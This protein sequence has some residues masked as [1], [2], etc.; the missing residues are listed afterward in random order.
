MRICGDYITGQISAGF[1]GIF[2]KMLDT[3]VNNWP[4]SP[5]PQPAQDQRT[6]GSIQSCSHF[7]QRINCIVSSSIYVLVCGY[8]HPN[9]TPRSQANPGGLIP[10]L[11][12]H[13]LLFIFKKMKHEYVHL[14][15]HVWPMKTWEGKITEWINLKIIKLI[16]TFDWSSH[17]LC[18]KSAIW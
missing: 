9:T 17:S 18:T 6:W 8:E 5:S 4:N 10:I 16:K 3:N 14:Q 1:F 13:F 15:L 7:L 12:L 11:P 2:L